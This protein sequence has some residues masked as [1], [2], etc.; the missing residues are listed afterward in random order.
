MTSEQ[1]TKNLH[2]QETETCKFLKTFLTGLWQTGHQ[3]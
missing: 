3:P 1:S 2:L